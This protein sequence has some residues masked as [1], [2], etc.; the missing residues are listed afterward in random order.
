MPRLLYLVLVLTL[1][2]C[3]RSRPE[4]IVITQTP[5]PQLNGMFTP[6]MVGSPTPVI[7]SASLSQPTPDPTRQGGGNAPREYVVK[8]GDTLSAIAAANNVSVETLLALNSLLD[9]NLLAV[10]QVLQLP[11]PP[12]EASLSFKII[13]D[14][15]LVRGPGSQD[16]DVNQFVANQS[17]Y[18]RTAID[19]VNGDVLSAAAVVE[20]VSLE[21]SVDARLLLTL[22]E[23]RAGWLTDLNPSEELRTYPLGA[24]ASPL[25]FDRNGLYRQ[26]TWAADQLNAG[27]YGWKYR[28]LSTM[29]FEDGE[30][31]GFASGLNA[32]T[33]GLQ[34]ML[35]QFNDYLGWQ[36]D[37]S[38]AG[39]YQTYVQYFGDPFAGA[40][41]PL[42]PIGI[43]Q[44]SLTLPF[45]SDEVWLFTGGPHGGWGSGS[46]WAAI[47]FA[48]PDDLTEVDSSCYVSEHWV[49]ASAN[50]VIARTADGVVILDLDG[51]GD[52]STGWSILY[53]HL[54]T[55]G[56]IA[57]DSIV[58]V[59]DRLGRPSC[60]GGF[61]NG[62]HVYIARRYNGEWLPADCTAC[63]AEVSKPSLV[64]GG[65]SVRNT[66]DF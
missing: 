64:L 4:I 38:S 55:D 3:L 26:L 49:T 13:P 42:V 41:D 29:T 28:G 60:E 30:R 45:S 15:R 14:S 18:I 27:Y 17:G 20:R 44:P 62:T 51:D 40:V 21:F 11:E 53:L 59:G 12:D 24:E 50:G 65:W 57:E 6:A 34:Y 47:D 61:S 8:A 7:P 58:N 32:G 1:T 10:G 19:T 16:F 56:R 52:E 33:I 2:A 23:Y 46:A 5:N 43:E 22:L 35:S 39:V 31:L 36:I 9:A 25:G 54:A 37:S 63:L 66:R 48:P